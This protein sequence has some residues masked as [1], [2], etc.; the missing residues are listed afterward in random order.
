MLS[1]RIKR[2]TLQS[3]PDRDGEIDTVEL[4]PREIREETVRR[5]KRPQRVNWVFVFLAC[6]FVVMLLGAVGL[7]ILILF[8]A[9]ILSGLY[10]AF[11]GIMAIFS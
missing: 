10:I 6:V 3:K 4:G 11:R 7:G 8:I 5:G 2:R 1:A 9:V